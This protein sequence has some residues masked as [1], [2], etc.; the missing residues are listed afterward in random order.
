MAS[1][2]ADDLQIFPPL[3]AATEA[4]LRASIEKFGVI[5]PVVVNQDGLIID[6]HHRS[7]IADEL[8]IPYTSEPVFTNGRE[9]A[10]ELART[11]NEDRRHMPREQ[12]VEVVQA[13]RD[14]G[15]SLRAIGEVVGVSAKTVHQ[16]LS[17][18]V[19]Q[20][21]PA[22]EAP[23]EARIAPEAGFSPR[24]RLRD[25]E[26]QVEIKRVTGTD[27]KS[28]PAVRQMPELEPA[29]KARRARE[30]QQRQAHLN[31]TNALIPLNSDPI[32]PDRYAERF[33]DS[34]G[35]RLSEFSPDDMEKAACVLL[36]MAAIRRSM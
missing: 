25:V 4:A 27:G 1:S 33:A 13:L 26:K 19:T 30:S 23:P 8:G 36:A 7:R 10:E 2:T 24:E 3:D 15:H 9:H 11:L 14:E 12:R 5:Y 31:L 35:E 16:D 21:T 29:E 34:L 20:V 18:G 28:Y 17:A 6:G 32:G 22:P